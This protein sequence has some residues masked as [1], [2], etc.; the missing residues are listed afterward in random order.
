MSATLFGG[1]IKYTKRYRLGQL[2]SDLARHYLLMSATPHNGK[3]E[4]CQLFMALLRLRPFRGPVP[5]RR[6]PSRDRE[7]S[8]KC[9]PIFPSRKAVAQRLCRRTA[10]EFMESVV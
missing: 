8:A 3:E 10:S 1:E 7:N 2:L 5:R 6:A 9:V 4:D